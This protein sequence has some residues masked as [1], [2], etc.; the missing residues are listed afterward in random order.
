MAAVITHTLSSQEAD[1]HPIDRVIAARELASSIPSAPHAERWPAFD[2]LAVLAQD[3]RP[4]LGDDG[5]TERVAVYPEIVAIFLEALESEGLI[6]SSL[7][8][9][10]F[11]LCG[12][13]NQLARREITQRTFAALPDALRT[14]RREAGVKAFILGIVGN[15][16]KGWIRETARAQTVADLPEDDLLAG[17]AIRS[18]LLLNKLEIGE[19]MADLAPKHRQIIDLAFFQGLSAAEIRTGLQLSD[20]QYRNRRRQALKEMAELLEERGHG[21]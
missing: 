19:V 5:R 8:A 7:L 6:E 10:R 15:Q 17:A 9:P 11:G 20:G 16:Y 3:D 4:I 21:R 12:A 13:E 14:Y 2:R 1:L 18:S